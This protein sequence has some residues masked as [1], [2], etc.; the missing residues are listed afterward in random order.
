MLTRPIKLLE[1]L[2]TLRVYEIV[3]DVSSFKLILCSDVSEYFVWEYI[4]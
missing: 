1:R 2:C 4:L 3:F